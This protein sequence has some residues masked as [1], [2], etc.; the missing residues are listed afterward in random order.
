MKKRY[1]KAVSRESS[2]IG[3]QAWNFGDSIELKKCFGWGF[4]S[5]YF[6]N[7]NGVI[8]LFAE[9]QEG[10]D[11]YNVIKE[12]LN[13]Q[14]FFNAL[15]EDFLDN[16]N[17]GEE[18]IKKEFLFKEKII[19]LFE[20]IIKCWPAIT[21]F[22]I[23]S[24]YPNIASQDTLEKLIKIRKETSKIIYK[25]KDKLIKYI[26][27]I[28][29]ELEDSVNY[30]KIK[31]FETGRFPLKKELEKRKQ[32]YVL[33]KDF[34]ETDKS[35]S[36]LSKE[37]GFEI[38]EEEISN[39]IKGTVAMEGSVIGKVKLIFKYQDTFKVE[40]G[41]IIV[42]SMTT[43]DYLIAMDKAAAFVTDEGGIT[44]H[45]AI[46]AREFKK[47]CIVGT[48]NA[49]KILKDGDLVLVNGETGIIEKIKCIKNTL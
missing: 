3:A 34:L 29:P 17:K 40:R 6:V 42:A 41:D 49:T 8:D 48:H 19:E 11:C 35:F 22:D 31:E 9:K 18:I 39:Q 14:G 20:I 27:K 13:Q 23:I 26:L 2:L 16:V 5:H 15:C 45:A 10:E 33:S 38:I 37:H 32:Y 1:K 12:K 4:E 44:C 47:P 24:N 46:I 43:P 21:I 36:N 28:Y 25:Y 30:I 7:K